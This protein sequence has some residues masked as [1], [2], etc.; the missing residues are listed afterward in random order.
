MR[1]GNRTLLRMP[2]LLE[3]DQHAVGPFP[4]RTAVR[5]R[6]RGLLPP[7]PDRLRG[8]RRRVDLLFGQPDRITRLKSRNNTHET[9]NPA[10]NSQTFVGRVTQN[11]SDPSD[12]I[13]RIRPVRP[14]RPRPPDHRTA[15]GDRGN[16]RRPPWPAAGVRNPL[17]PGDLLRNPP[18]GGRSPGGGDGWD[19]FDGSDG[20]CRTDRSGAKS[21]LCKHLPIIGLK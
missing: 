6:L 19:G 10:L 1:H 16:T 17:A 5:R 7:D 2:P 21:L 14:I 13:R 4:G 8:V 9:S 20:S 3:P 11:P 12:A 15:A 18:L